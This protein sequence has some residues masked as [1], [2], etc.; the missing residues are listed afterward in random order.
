MHFSLVDLRLMVR[1]ADTSSITRAAEASHLSLSAVSTRIKGLEESVGA[2]LLHRTSQ[3]VTLTA[4]GQAIVRHAR[5]V[6]AQLEHMRADLHQYTLGTRGQLR[7]FANTTALGEYLPPVLRRYLRE[8]PG[9]S[10]DLRER[11]SPDIVRAVSGGQADIGIVA[12]DVCTGA[13]ET[14]PYRNDRLVVVVPDGHAL[15]QAGEVGF[16]DTLEWDHV[17]LHDASAIHAFL[18]QAGART[19]RV[20]N[21]RI[22]VGSVEAVCRMVEAT[23]G[24]AVLPESAVRRHA[25]EMAVA[26]VPLTDA[27]AMRAMQVCVRCLAALPPYARDLLDLLAQDAAANGLADGAG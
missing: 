4:P 10:V 22:Q 24:V 23:V 20:R 21:V 19:R 3:G 12:G 26:I 17:E 11:L 14:V 25:R 1:I 7:L 9:V 5:L 15:E 6:L 13:L 16:G 2:G 8:H 27:W 18:H